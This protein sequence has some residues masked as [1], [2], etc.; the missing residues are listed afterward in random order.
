MLVQYVETKSD[1]DGKTTALVLEKDD[2][3]TV[4]MEVEK[5]LLEK[6]KP[7]QIEGV[8]VCIKKP[9]FQ[10]TYFLDVEF[11][12]IKFLWGC[13]C[14]NTEKC[15][16]TAGTGCIVAHAMGMGKSLQ[17]Y[18]YKIFIPCTM[19]RVLKL[20]FQVITFLH[21]VLSNN[22]TGFRTCLLIAPVNTLSNW[23]KEFVHWQNDLSVKIEVSPNVFDSYSIAKLCL[24]SIGNSHK[25]SKVK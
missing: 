19:S 16:S 21:T 14:V 13:V 12:G 10:F 25:E 7:H 3:G 5:Q 17:V 6:L 24:L 23:E 4:T 8:F 9:H 22:A 2:N 11:T 1:V 15:N 18:I 20:K